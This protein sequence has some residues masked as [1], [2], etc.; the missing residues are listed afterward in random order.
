MFGVGS[1]GLARRG[2]NYVDYEVKE[3]LDK[4]SVEQ[5]NYPDL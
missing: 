3:F 1:Q 4:M 2:L 5:A